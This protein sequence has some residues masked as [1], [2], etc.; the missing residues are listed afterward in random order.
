M[1]V[2]SDNLQLITNALA[3]PEM[4][5]ILKSMSSYERKLQKQP[6]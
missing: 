1:K 3:T 4:S 2:Y 6:K 5:L